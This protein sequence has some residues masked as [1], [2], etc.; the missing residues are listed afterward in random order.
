MT[1]ILVMMTGDTILLLLVLR[2]IKLISVH[3][4]TFLQEGAS[5][6]PQV[7]VLTNET[8]EMNTYGL[9]MGCNNIGSILNLQ[10]NIYTS[11]GTHSRRCSCNI[12]CIALYR[13]NSQFCNH[14]SHAPDSLSHCR[15]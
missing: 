3:D 12:F 14:P 7:L 6:P 8:V 10:H 13:R 2:K 5:V 1:T 15:L 9:S 4:I 11:G